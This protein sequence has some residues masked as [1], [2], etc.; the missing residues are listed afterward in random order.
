ME[1]IVYASEPE[2]LTEDDLHEVASDGGCCGC[3]P[4]ISVELELSV[5]VCL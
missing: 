1:D 4:S 2:E 3:G 5:A